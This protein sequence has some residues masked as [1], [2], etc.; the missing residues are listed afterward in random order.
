MM[1]KKAAGFI[2]LHRQILDWE[3]YGDTNTFRLFIHILLSANFTDGR[4]E[5]R[6][7]HRGQLVTSLTSLSAQT[8][9]SVRQVRVSLDKLQ[10]TGEL[11]S[12]SFNRY[13]IITVVKY[14]QYQSV[15]KQNDR[16]MTSEMSSKRQ[17]NDRQMTSNVTSKWQQYNN[18]NNIN[19]V[20]KETMEQERGTAKRF[21]PPTKDEIEIFCLENGL[22]ID[23]DRFVDY[24]TANGWIVGKTK[25]KDWQATVRNWA[26][27][28]QGAVQQQRKPA[29][30]RRE[31]S[32]ANFEQRDYSD[33][34]A[35]MM[36]SLAEEVEQARRDGII[37]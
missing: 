15:D 36:R 21:T 19:N 3:W 5:G 17:A 25:M 24:Y 11:T 28:D 23:V 4:F 7:I 29:P 22:T 18:D 2:T 14:D 31:N 6:T 33:V 20:N 37:K 27:R 26:R 10:M 16:Q 30:V 8:S 9:L 1:G 12:Q 32:A 35:E 13:R 34:N